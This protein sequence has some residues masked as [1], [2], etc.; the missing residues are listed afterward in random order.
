MGN[1]LFETV[2]TAAATATGG[3]GTGTGMD[4]DRML[5]GF[6]IVIGLIALYSAITGKGPA[7]KND[8]PKA[9]QADAN[10]LMR[11]FCWVIGPV[12][13]VFGVLDYMGYVW[14]TWV[15]IGFTI[16]A[17]VVYMIIFRKRFGKLLK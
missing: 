2:A 11:M 1:I 9:I 14:A 7:Y 3:T 5:S 13:T 16:S 6:T 17:I 4:M 12:V 8:Y 10:K 15:N